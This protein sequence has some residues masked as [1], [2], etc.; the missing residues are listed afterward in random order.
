MKHFRRY[1]DH[2]IFHET[3][4]AGRYEPSEVRAILEILDP[5]STFSAKFSVFSG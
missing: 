4:T 3:H 2:I 1:T 5:F